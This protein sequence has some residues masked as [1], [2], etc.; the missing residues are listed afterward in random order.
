MANT[1]ITNRKVQNGPVLDLDLGSIAGIERAG[2]TYSGNPTETATPYGP[3][4]TLDGPNTTDYLTL[5]N[6]PTL[7]FD[8]SGE[9]SLEL[10]MQFTTLGGH[11]D[12]FSNRSGVDGYMLA[13]ESTTGKLRLSPGSWGSYVESNTVVQADTWY[14]M[15]LTYNN[16]AAAY[17]LNG[18]SDGSGSLLTAT[19]LSASPT[20]WKP[21]GYG[22]SC[23]ADITFIRMYGTE[24]SQADVTALYNKVI[25]M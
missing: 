2:F 11:Q 23:I 1:P 15:V 10:L 9:F 4:L 13:L 12:I 25:L 14:H 5:T 17:Y 20:V 3:G 16:L 7:A 18:S 22:N 24:L 21:V 19:D 8:A 6:T